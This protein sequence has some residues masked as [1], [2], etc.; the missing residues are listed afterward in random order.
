SFGF[1]VVKHIDVPVTK[2]FS[3]GPSKLEFQVDEGNIVKKEL[4]IFNAS[5]VDSL[6]NISFEDIFDKATVTPGV[7]KISK[8]LSVDNNNFLL[9]HGEEAVIDVFVKVPELNTDKFVGGAV[10]VSRRDASS[11]ATKISARLGALVFVDIGKMAKRSGYV[12]NFK[13][14]ED[15]AFDIVFKNTGEA[16]LNPYGFIE[17][18]NIL[19]DYSG[20][21]VVS[22]WYVLPGTERTLKINW[23]R[24]SV[25]SPVYN[26]HLVMYPGF[27]GPE[28]TENISIRVYN[29]CAISAYV[30][31]SL[32]FIIIFIKYIRHA[33]K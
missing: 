16:K 13:Y 10:L 11:D 4:H 32:L 2:S 21:S 6:F 26:A 27:G 33:K 20:R 9:K 17:F 3:I 30:I 15:G 18:R 19:G 14:L 12:T 28:G 31:L 22:P 25:F 5:G 8:Y 23:E 29:F 24:P 1:S 7:P